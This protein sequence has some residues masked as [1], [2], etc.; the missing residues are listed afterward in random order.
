MSITRFSQKDPKVA[1]PSK[2]LIRNTAN[3]DM[4]SARQ[5]DVTI[6]SEELWNIANFDLIKT[7]Y[8]C[9][10]LFKKLI[11]KGTSDITRNRLFLTPYSN[12]KTSDVWFI[13]IPEG[14]IGISKWIIH[15]ERV[16]MKIIRHGSTSSIRSYLQLNQKF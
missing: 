16:L 7:Y 12:W 9:C 8:F 3:S 4:C 5:T 15:T 10:K 13:N 11:E 14:R 1:S 6:I 2:W